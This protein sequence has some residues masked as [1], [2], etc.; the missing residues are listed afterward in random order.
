ML[1]QMV[2]DNV[3]EER[4]SGTQLVSTEMIHDSVFCGK[5]KGNIIT[6]TTHVNHD[7]PKQINK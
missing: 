6:R 2:H 7:I 1:T 5:A 3:F 4:V